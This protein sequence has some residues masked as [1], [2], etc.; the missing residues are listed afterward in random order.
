MNGQHIR[1]VDDEHLCFNCKYRFTASTVEPCVKCLEFRALYP[2]W[3]PI[4]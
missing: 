2:Y 4:I 1:N 3:K